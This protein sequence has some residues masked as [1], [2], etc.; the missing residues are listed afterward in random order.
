MT[1]I[2]DSFKRGGTAGDWS[3]GEAF[4]KHRLSSIQPTRIDQ[5]IFSLNFDT[6]VNGPFSSWSSNYTVVPSV[7]NFIL[8]TDSGAAVEF[9][10]TAKNTFRMKWDSS[11][12]QPQE[13][14]CI[15][16]SSVERK[17]CTQ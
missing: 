10:K 13:A 4:T 17:L 9:F 8:R 6:I 16:I 14:I 11:I 2:I 1:V 5:N 7:K 15:G 12:I 3:W